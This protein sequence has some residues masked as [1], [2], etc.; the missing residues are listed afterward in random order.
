MCMNDFLCRVCK[1]KIKRKEFLTIF[2]DREK[3]KYIILMMTMKESYVEEPQYIRIYQVLNLR[4]RDCFQTKILR[5]Q[6]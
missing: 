6:F 5:I 2:R 3:A 4:K 1:K